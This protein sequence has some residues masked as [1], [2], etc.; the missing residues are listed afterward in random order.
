M[1]VARVVWRLIFIALWCLGSSGCLES[2]NSSLDEQKDSYYRK[3]KSLL[4]NQ[5]YAG[6]V[7][8]FEKALEINPRNA[9][10]HFELWLLYEQ[11]L[12]DYAASI[13]HGERFLRLRPDSDH[14]KTVRDRIAGSKLELAKELPV[15][16]VIPALYHDFERLSESNKFL[17]L[18]VEMLTRQLAVATN[19]VLASR[20]AQAT[21]TAAPQ[22]TGAASANTNPVAPL[23]PTPARPSAASSVKTHTIKAGDTF[24]KV[25]RQYR[26]SLDA[27]M[28]ANPG[29]NPKKL[30]VGQTIKLPAP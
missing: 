1:S 17:R 28:A 14:A 3:G 21:A 24:V 8:A 13:Y 11:Q 22:V 12:K 27:L 23:A 19:L 10:A 16:P 25:A 9:S 18:Q 4:G 30:R 5:D 7:A 6:A 2:P 26:V 15:G 20:L 29:L